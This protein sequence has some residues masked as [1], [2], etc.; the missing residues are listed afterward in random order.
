[1]Q[2]AVAISVATSLSLHL[3]GCGGGEQTTPPP[4]PHGHTSTRTTM[5]TTVTS[6]G[7]CEP[8]MSKFGTDDCFFKCESNL[9]LGPMR[10]VENK[11][12]VLDD[13][14]MHWCPEKLQFQWPNTNDPIK[15][16]RM[17]KAWTDQWNEPWLSKQVAWENLAKYLRASQGK[18]LVG[19]SIT[20][21][22]EQDDAD[23]ENVMEMLK[24][25]GADHVMGVAIGNE[26]ELLWTKSPV[27]VGLQNKSELD[28]CLERVWNEGYF[29]DKFHS[30]VKDLDS[31]GAGFEKVMLTSVFGGFILAGE[32]F[33]EARV[34][35]QWLGVARVVTFL[36]NVTEVFG[37]RYA[38][39][40]NIYP[41]FDEEMKNDKPETEPPTCKKALGVATCFDG[42]KDEDC[43]FTSVVSVMRERLG[44]IG[45]ASSLLWIGETGWSYPKAATLA[46][47]H[48]TQWCP[49]WSSSERFQEYYHNFI[50]WNMSMKG[51]YRGPDHI[52]Y[53]SARDS[54]NF[55]HIEGFG[56]VGGGNPE[57]WCTNTT[58]K[59]QRK[60]SPACRDNPGCE[61]LWND[62]CPT[63]EGG[64]LKCCQSALNN[65]SLVAV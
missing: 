41:Y 43:V 29:L 15:S 33:Y 54:S 26:L 19:T 3:F 35:S 49:E 4:D 2:S 51:D 61:G 11:G 50:N 31:L 12:I 46:G 18:V 1:M 25:F 47:N 7:E 13:T 5:T 32:P 28:A 56:L 58:C 63:K 20:C 27:D 59:L 42:A 16:F 53:F 6:S 44:K 60:S 22:E 62:C 48:E 36:T 34:P 23:W 14:T 38:H 8:G 57:A 52:F 65:M 24:V 37:D 39:S 9:M 55:G 45:N 21:H 64:Y 40:L 17:Y 30:R 10:R